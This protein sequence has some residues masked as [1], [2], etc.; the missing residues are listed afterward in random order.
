M[1]WVEYIPNLIIM[2]RIQLNILIVLQFTKNL[3]GEL[4]RFRV[5]EEN[6]LVVGNYSH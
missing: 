5:E 3:I 1:V 4:I 6:R 2:K